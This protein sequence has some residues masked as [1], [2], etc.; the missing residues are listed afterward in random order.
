M[1]FDLK[2]NSAYYIIKN[3][4]DVYLSEAKHYVKENLDIY[5]LYENITSKEDVYMF[6][7]IETRYLKLFER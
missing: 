5:E 2:K 7:V 4:D 1:E 6:E 3:L